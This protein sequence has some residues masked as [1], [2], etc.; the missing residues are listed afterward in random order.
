MA[1]DK[2]KAEKEALKAQEKI[3]NGFR[4]L[5]EQQQEILGELSTLEADMRELCGVI[6]VMKTLPGTRKIVRVIGDVSLESTV[7]EDL[8][9]KHLEFNERADLHRVLLKKLQEKS[10]EIVAYQKEHSIRILSEDEVADLQ[11]KNQVQVRG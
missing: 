11:K 7:E 6:K 2:K 4:E 1:T 3:V 8:K 10:E 9:K 5:R